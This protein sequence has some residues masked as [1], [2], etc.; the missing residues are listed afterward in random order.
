VHGI[1]SLDAPDAWFWTLQS[2]TL[3][4]TVQNEE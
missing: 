3:D 2:I 1:T 4:R